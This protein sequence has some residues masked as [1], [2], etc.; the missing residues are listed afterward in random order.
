MK[1][2]YFILQNTWLTG[3]FGHGWGNGY[4]VIPPE[5]PFYSIDYDQL[6]DLV[7]V[8]G[9]L[10]FSEYGKALKKWPG[11]RPE[12][13]QSWVIGFDTCHYEDDIYRWPKSAVEDEVKKLAEQCEEWD[14]SYIFD[15]NFHYF[16]KQP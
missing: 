10:T 2:E 3:V 9:G 4:V 7:S 16:R 6:N 14:R 8:H 15:I 12:H 11:Y 1:L 5:H 13:E